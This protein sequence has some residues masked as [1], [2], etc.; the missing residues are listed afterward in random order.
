V[1]RGERGE[2]LAGQP[3]WTGRVITILRAIEG[4]ALGSRPIAGA[5]G[6]GRGFAP[7]AGRAIQ[8]TEALAGVGAAAHA[9]RAIGPAQA[10]VAPDGPSFQAL[11]AEDRDPEARAALGAFRRAYPTSLAAPALEEAVLGHALP[12]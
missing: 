10:L 5:T 6:L 3:P 2:H 12:R 9:D 1:V 8:G 11:V 4:A 7:F